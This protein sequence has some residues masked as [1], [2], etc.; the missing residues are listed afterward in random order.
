MTY[1][2]N[3]YSFVHTHPS[4]GSPV[5]EDGHSRRREDRY[6]GTIPITITCRTPLLL[7]DHAAPTTVSF[8]GVDEPRPLLGLRT[9]PDGK[10]LLEGSAVKG[11]L[12]TAFE[13]VT[14]S[15]MGAFG[16]HD[17]PLTFRYPQY[18][19]KDLRPAIV[20]GREEDSVTLEV[21]QALRP[22]GNMNLS[23]HPAPWVPRHCPGLPPGER[24]GVEVFAWIHLYVHER[25]NHTG[26][27]LVWRAAVCGLTA[28]QLPAAAPAAPLGGHNLNAQGHSAL[29][30]G[31]LHW[32][33][34]M[35][36]GKHDER[37]VVLEVLEG[38]HREAQQVEVGAA[39]IRRWKLTIDSYAAGHRAG[40]Q[41]ARGGYGEHPERWDLQPGRTL[42]ITGSGD[43]ATLVPALISRGAYTRSP[44]ELLG[45]HAPATTWDQAT[46]ADWVF[47]WTA[48]GK[49]DDGVAAHRAHLRVDPPCVDGEAFVSNAPVALATLN[50]PKPNNARF[51]AKGTPPEVHQDHT[52]AYT[53][54]HELN[55]WKFYEFE[56]RLALWGSLAPIATETARAAAQ[57]YWTPPA[58]SHLDV[59]GQNPVQVGTTTADFPALYNYLPVTRY[60]EYLAPP[61][62][63]PATV[64]CVAGWVVPPTRFR[65][66]LH[67]ENLTERQLGALLGLL[68]MP[69]DA[70]MRLGMGRPLGFGVVRVEAAL[71]D[72]R[73]RTGPAV[74]AAVLLGR[75]DDDHVGL[76][77]L[78]SLAWPGNHAELAPFFSIARGVND[79]VHYP[80]PDAA[81][82]AT[83]YTWHVENNRGQPPQ[84]AVLPIGGNRRLSRR[85]PGGA[86]TVL[87]DRAGRPAPA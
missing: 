76:E 37:L 87:Y 11:M 25:P 56:R 22:V 13:A 17:L 3:P 64:T 19:A 34:G 7:P 85:P 61:G 21:V 38:A 43:T 36:Q 12:R 33:G 6:H 65:T 42:H 31:V 39:P 50:S 67:V 45:Q 26:A 79:P 24:D 41:N 28:D 73:I 74:R 86:V 2:V 15:R 5:S 75:S 48:P 62:F 63:K 8:D 44:R 54:D 51:Y 20:T 1:F 81:P 82:T 16:A 58:V 60:R 84:G 30:R 80:R 68:N 23:P 46:D 47:G 66:T 52:T 55:G 14:G 10:P 49:I 27:G 70:A 83:G 77:D 9:A 4:Q 18:F 69:D 32:T 57:A 72:T 78:R 59:G 53:E 35:I 29:V 40:Q 71:A